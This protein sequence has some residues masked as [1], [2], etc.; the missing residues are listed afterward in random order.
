MEHHTEEFGWN[1][2]IITEPKLS[3]WNES[4]EQYNILLLN[5]LSY[6]HTE[7]EKTKYFIWFISEN[8]SI[9]TRNSVFMGTK[10]IVGWS[11][12][13]SQENQIIIKVFNF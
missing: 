6:F 10:I 7:E 11:L 12:F 9:G 4:I 1:H 8:E 2:A 3:V 13:S 5:Y